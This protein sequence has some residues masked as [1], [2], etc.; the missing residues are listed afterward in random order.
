M[1]C[2]GK[3]AYIY[4]E[5][6]NNPL[7]QYFRQ[8]AI[9][10]KL[11]SNGEFYPDG[12]ITMPA[13]GELPVLPMTAIDEITY[14]TPDAL[15]N[16]TAVINVIESCVPNIHNAWAVPSTDLDTILV[17]IRIA[18]YGHDMEVNCFCPKCENQDRYTTDLRQA[19]DTLASG[20]YNQP[21]LHRDLEIYFRPM[22]YKMLNQNNQLQFEEQ[23]VLQSLAQSSEE[24]QQAQS[25]VISTILKRITDMTIGSLSQSISAIKAPSSI[26]TD[27]ASIEEFLRNCD[28]KLFTIIRDH[29]IALKANSELKP[30]SV[31]CTSCENE[32]DQSFTLDMSSFFDRAS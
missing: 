5:K 6:M 20:D 9:Y 19:I 17:G 8:P 14:R 16:G 12:A 7:S 29:V 30:L 21:I 18:T 10:I 26:V 22:N 4:G 15:F 13:N 1:C 24:S 11:P 2:A 27:Q 3:Y 32:Y 28:R 23:R 31:K 25:N